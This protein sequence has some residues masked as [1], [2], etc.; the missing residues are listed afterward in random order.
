MAETTKIERVERVERLAAMA[1]QAPQW[2]M[3]LLPEPAPGDPVLGTRIEW[4]F[5]YAEFMDLER[6]E[7]IERAEDQHEGWGLSDLFAEEKS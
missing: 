2:W 5:F 1:A 3:D 4:A 6:L 7:R